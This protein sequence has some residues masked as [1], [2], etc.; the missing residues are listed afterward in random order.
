MKKALL[1]SL[2][3]FSSSVFAQDAPKGVDFFNG[4]FKQALAKAKKE[5]KLV[6]FDAYT[7]WCGPCKVLK[8]K[9]FPNKE[10]G[11]YINKHFVSIGVD[12]EAGEGIQLS[13]MYPVDGYPTILFLD[14]EGKVKKKILGLPRGG[15]QELLA[16]AKAIN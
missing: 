5:N 3:L 7:T 2:I 9:V 13:N 8:T 15:A 16:I 11:E 6:M 14:G 1:F 4:T 10:L 12:M